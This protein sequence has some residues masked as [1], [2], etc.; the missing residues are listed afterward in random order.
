MS[1]EL[2]K[3]CFFGLG[4]CAVWGILAL[5][6]LRWPGLLVDWQGWWETLN[7][8]TW[9]SKWKEELWAPC[10]FCFDLVVAGRTT[11]N[12]AGPLALVA[13]AVYFSALLERRM[14][15]ALSEI[16]RVHD[17]EVIGQVILAIETKLGVTLNDEQRAWVLER[18]KSVKSPWLADVDVKNESA[19]GRQGT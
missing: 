19:E 17:I 10:P 1:S 9:P 12:L 14:Q 8:A 6:F 4:G 2:R 5:A 7:G 16:L 11:L 15:M 3:L 18:G 13:S